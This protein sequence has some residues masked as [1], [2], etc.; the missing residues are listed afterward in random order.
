MNTLNVSVFKDK[1]T[2]NSIL[3]TISKDFKTTSNFFLISWAYFL[4]TWAI[5]FDVW[6]THVWS[7]QESQRRWKENYKFGLATVGITITC[8]RDKYFI[9]VLKYKVIYGRVYD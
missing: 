8:G 4:L 1:Q 6:R 2:N 5:F 9:A 3:R 7:F